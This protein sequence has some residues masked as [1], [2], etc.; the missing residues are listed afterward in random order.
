MDLMHCYIAILFAVLNEFGGK[1]VVEAGL[2]EHA[3]IAI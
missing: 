1:V 2:I 3:Q